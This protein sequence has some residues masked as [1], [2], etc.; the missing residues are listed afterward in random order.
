MWIASTKGWFSVVIDT[1]RPGRMLVRACCR[2][3]I[4]D[5]YEANKDLASIEKPT[6]DESRDYRWRM[7]LDRQDW[8]TLVGQL[9]AAVDYPNF[10]SAV[11]KEP[12]Q[13]NKSEAYH[14]VWTTLHELQ[15]KENHG[16]DRNREKMWQ[17]A[18]REWDGPRPKKKQPKRK[19]SRKAKHVPDNH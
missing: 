5:L 17:D 8:L 15:R 19:R 9:A 12:S 10:K 2:Q 3:D 7:S 13:Q 1:R 14:D 11:A 4:A 16:K 6:S 18:V